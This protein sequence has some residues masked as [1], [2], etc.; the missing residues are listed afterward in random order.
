MCQTVRVSPPPEQELTGQP[1]V[2]RHE[3][4]ADPGM[5]AT[6]FSGPDPASLHQIRT[7]HPHVSTCQ[8]LLTFL[9]KKVISA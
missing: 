6:G 5:V 9:A 2:C 4:H 7:T 3:R 1:P 8:P